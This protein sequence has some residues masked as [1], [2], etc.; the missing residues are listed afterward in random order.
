MAED[1]QTQRRVEFS[2]TDAA[3]IAH[4]SAFMRYMEQAEHEFLRHLGTSVIEELPDGKHLSWP[5]VRVE[6][7]FQGT[8]KFEDVLDIAVRVR[9]LGNKSVT[10]SFEFECRS[11]PVA[12]GLVVVVCCE[13][14]VGQSFQSVSIPAELRRKLECYQLP[15]GET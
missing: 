13:V 7:D 10:Y 9:K 3:G 11:K 4:F 15:A 5:R 14:Q 1:F 2:D 12:R 8:A 6:C